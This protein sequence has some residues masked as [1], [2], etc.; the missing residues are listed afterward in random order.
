VGKSNTGRGECDV[1]AREAVG[2]KFWGYMEGRML[3]EADVTG[4]ARQSGGTCSSSL[5]ALLG[6]FAGLLCH[7][8][9]T[10]SPR[11]LSNAHSEAEEAVDRGSVTLC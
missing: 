8:Q 2:Q 9:L 3:R 1:A 5:R 7:A 4:P 11:P 10:Q 6:L